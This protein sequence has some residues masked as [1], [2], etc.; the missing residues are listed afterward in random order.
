MNHLDDYREERSQLLRTIS[1]KLEKDP[2]V[3]AAWLFGSLGRGDEDALSDLDLWVVVDD[4]HIDPIRADPRQVTSQMGHPILFLE[5]P[6]NAPFAGAYLMTCYDAPVAPHIVDWYWQPQ[7]HAF[8]PAQV[9][10]LFDRADLPHNDQPIRLADP[11]PDNEIV[12]RPMHIISFFWMMLMINA[13]RA[14]RDPLAPEMAL[15]PYLIDPM[16]KI[17]QILSQ[18]DP[19]RIDN[20]P[21]HSLPGEKIQL[22]YT[23]ANQMREWMAALVERG[24]QVPDLIAPGAYRYLE[25][26]SKNISANSSTRL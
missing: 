26:V 16:T 3:K 21:P 14:W 20:L 1:E 18:S 13:K 15:L 7:S 9:R 10:L 22:L 19:L 8:I 5:A 23:L 17:Q 12:E 25:F 6:Q 4:A 11:P 24:E 2:T